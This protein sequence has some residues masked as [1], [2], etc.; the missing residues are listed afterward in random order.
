MAGVNGRKRLRSPSLS[1][2]SDVSSLS[3]TEHERPNISTL[4]TE[5]QVF[6]S[7]EI[8]LNPD[9][10][11]I[12]FLE[13]VTI[14]Q[15]DGNI[16][17]LLEVTPTKKFQVIGR[18]WIDEEDASERKDLKYRE[19][20]TCNNGMGVTDIQAVKKKSLNG[21][22]IKFTTQGYSQGSK[23]VVIWALGEGR[24]FEIQ[25]S[26]QY[27]SRYSSM[28]QGRRLAQRKRAPRLSRHS[29]WHLQ[30]DSTESSL[31]KLNSLTNKHALI[32][33]SMVI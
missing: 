27:R 26:R 32:L 17:D 19:S 7:A 31:C 14:T 20:M 9:D 8:L 24:W 28:T 6:K 12:F 5:S 21:S 10:Y 23:P 11:P 18:L 15:E 13:D 25:P 3:E 29:S 1:D 33:Y 2:A 4:L 30:S 16:A 22:Y